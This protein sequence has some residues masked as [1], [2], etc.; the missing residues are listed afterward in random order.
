PPGRRDP[1]PPHLPGVPGPP[2]PTPPTPLPARPGQS[3]PPHQPGPPGPPPQT[4]HTTTQERRRK[5]R[6]RQTGEE[7][8]GHRVKGTTTEGRKKTWGERAPPHTRPP[9]RDLTRTSTLHSRATSDRDGP[10]PA[11]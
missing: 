2:P 9:T 1:P 10:P 11:C 8:Q 3:P 7:G 6:V 4:I 5:Q